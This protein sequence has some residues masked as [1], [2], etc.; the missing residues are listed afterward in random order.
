MD[1]LNLTIGEMDVK[2]KRMQDVRVPEGWKIADH[3]ED[4]EQ[5]E[6]KKESRPPEKWKRYKDSPYL[7][8]NYGRV[9]RNGKIRK[10]KFDTKGYSRVNLT[11]NGIREEPSIHRTVM[12]LFGT[13][14]RPKGATLVNH[15][16]GNIKN[17]AIWNLEWASTSENTEYAYRKGEI[18]GKG[19]RDDSIKSV[20]D[21]RKQKQKRKE[22]EAEG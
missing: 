3:G 6:E 17:N 20:K 13:E 18:D 10:P 4:E 22:R 1:N 2:D 8:S 16:D 12:Q 7:F 11:W 19:E 5:K 21:I 15:K 14:K 9:S